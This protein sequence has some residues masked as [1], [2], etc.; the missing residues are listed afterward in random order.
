MF[1]GG[2]LQLTTERHKTQIGVV[3]ESETDEIIGAAIEVHRQ[4]GPGLLE[5]IY[6]AC[7][8]RELELRGIPHERQVT[9]PVSYKG[10]LLP[11]EQR[12]DV[13]VRGKVIV[14][15]KAVERLLPVHSA[16]LLTYMRLTNIHV[17]LLFN[18]NVSRLTEGIVRRVL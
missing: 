5:S 14:E 12:I 10:V 6:E 7:F 4:L 1:Y 13:L 3:H 11:C 18:F 16:Q 17:G 2:L 8:C 15:L 9:V